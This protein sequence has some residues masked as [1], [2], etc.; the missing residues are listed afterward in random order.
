MQVRNSTAGHEANRF[1]K[2]NYKAVSSSLEKMSS[3]LKINRAGD[4]AAGLMVS[5]KLRSQ[6]AGFDKAADNSEDGANLIQTGEGALQE[7]HDMLTRL[8]ELA[9]QSANGTYDDDVDRAVMQQEVDQ[10]FSEIDRIADSTDFNGIPLLNSAQFEFVDNYVQ[11][12]MD[13]FGV[14]GLTLGSVDFSA[15]DAANLVEL[16]KEFT[17]AIN[18]EDLLG[19][20]AYDYSPQIGDV[21]YN[22]YEVTITL[23]DGST[24]TLNIEGS[25]VS[26]PLDTVYEMAKASFDLSNKTGEATVSMFYMDGQVHF[27]SEDESLT[28]AGIA[29]NGKDVKTSEELVTFE[30]IDTS[31]SVEG[32]KIVAN[33]TTCVV[34]QNTNLVNDTTS[35]VDVLDVESMFNDS[36]VPISTSGMFSNSHILKIPVDVSEKEYESIRLQVGPTSEGENMMD[37]P[38]FDIHVDALDISGFDITTLENAQ[39]SLNMVNDAINQISTYRGEY[40][41]VQS[42]IDYNIQNMI[43]MRD[44]LTWAESTIRDTDVA[45]EMMEYTMSNI[46]L[47]SSEA[48]MAHTNELLE[49]VLSLVQNM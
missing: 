43:N 16:E 26:D 10:I 24:Q 5:E 15:V 8:K 42:R 4:D 12:F 2:K 44:N 22:P 41:A 25:T 23:S 46:R 40:G 3:G 20:V 48:M 47:Q 1:M 38:K 36:G 21:Y 35:V 9:V 27:Y 49:S 33:G 14:D 39:E 6:V 37:V 13:G 18:L 11:L 29:V 7:V 19:N 17:A 30:V 32:D 34:S 31:G 28:V 45:E